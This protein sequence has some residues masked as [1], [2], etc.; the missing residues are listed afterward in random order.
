[1]K[2]DSLAIEGQCLL[3]LPRRPRPL[4]QPRL[5]LSPHLLGFLLAIGL[6]HTSGTPR[7]RLRSLTRPDLQI[8]DSD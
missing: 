2:L 5:E 8:Q 4:K 1:M 7:W 3:L 6:P